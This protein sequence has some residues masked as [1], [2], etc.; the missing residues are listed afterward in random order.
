[1]SHHHH[2]HQTARPLLFIGPQ[3]D[4]RLLKAAERGDEATVQALLEDRAVNIE[5]KDRVRCPLIG[6][7]DL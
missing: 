5:A 3:M 2:H 1:M 7:S 6:V 4:E